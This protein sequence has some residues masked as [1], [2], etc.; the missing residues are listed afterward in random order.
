MLQ[1][2]LCQPSLSL[3]PPCLRP[4]LP[5]CP[6]CPLHTAG[7]C[8]GIAF[9]SLKNEDTENISYIIPTPGVCACVCACLCVCWV[10]VLSVCVLVLSR[11][12]SRRGGGGAMVACLR[13][14]QHM[15]RGSRWLPSLPT[16]GH[17]I[18]TP[19]LFTASHCLLQNPPLTSASQSSS[20]FTSSH[21]SHRLPFPLPPFTAHQ[22]P[23]LLTLPLLTHHL[24]C[25]CS[26]PAL[27]QRLR[28]QRNLHRLPGTGPG[29][30]EDGE[31]RAEAG[32]GHA[33]VVWWWCAVG[34]VTGRVEGWAEGFVGRCGGWEGEG[35][36]P[37]GWAKGRV[38]G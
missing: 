36:V 28:A 25:C 2:F 19:L 4:S 14:A 17:A 9:Q 3:P 16:P 21:V 8:V 20:D 37:L 13:E 29:V 35:R 31:P 18:A 30:A 26:H 7:E 24:T 1:L 27:H 12:G 10:C 33:G 38:K 34:W 32:A 23:L 22:P 6:P 15:W 11:R 5:P